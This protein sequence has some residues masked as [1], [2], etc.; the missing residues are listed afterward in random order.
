GLLQ[1]KNLSSQRDLITALLS[2]RILRVSN[3]EV[4]MLDIDEIDSKEEGVRSRMTDEN[5]HIWK[6][7]WD[8]HFGATV[9]A[10]GQLSEFMRSILM[11]TLS[12][13]II[14]P[15]GVV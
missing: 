11:S 13:H 6:A 10:Y 8:P 14:I 5:Y 2:D 3:A 4:T 1:H 15:T 12:I 9:G 7:M